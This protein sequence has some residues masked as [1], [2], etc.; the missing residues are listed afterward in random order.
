MP[1]GK[2]SSEGSATL[3]NRRIK[4]TGSHR[5]RAYQ[6]FFWTLQGWFR[7]FPPFQLTG[8]DKS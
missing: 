4:V 5:Y 7:H 8:L 3:N 6:G 2:R 1:E